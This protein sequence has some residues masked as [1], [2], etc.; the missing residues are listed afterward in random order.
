MVFRLAEKLNIQVFAST[1]SRDCISGFASAWEK[2]EEAGC[3]FRLNSGL[4]QQTTVTMYNRET[5]SDALE[6]DVEVR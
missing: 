5:L 1:H 3:F 2:N 4:N 6:T